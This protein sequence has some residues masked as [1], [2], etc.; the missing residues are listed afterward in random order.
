MA[1]TSGFRI[2]FVLSS[3]VNKYQSCLIIYIRLFTTT[4]IRETCTL[5]GVSERHFKWTFGR[6]NGRQIFRTAGQC[7]VDDRMTGSCDDSLVV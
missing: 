5:A 6:D 1:E 2:L 4:D 7:G 3:C